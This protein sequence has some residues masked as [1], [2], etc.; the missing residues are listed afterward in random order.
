MLNGISVLLIFL[1][2]LTKRNEGKKKGY[3]NGAGYTSSN[4]LT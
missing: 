2:V 1:M 3:Y 4:Y